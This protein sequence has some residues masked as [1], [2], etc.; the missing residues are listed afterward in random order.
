M[1]FKSAS[2]EGI[3]EGTVELVKNYLVLRKSIGGDSERFIF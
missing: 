2:K 3:K 1:V